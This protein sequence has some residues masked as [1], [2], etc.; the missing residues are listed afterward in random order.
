[1]LYSKVVPLTNLLK[2]LTNSSQNNT[3]MTS[4][5]EQLLQLPALCTQIILEKSKQEKGG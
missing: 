1:M 2:M 5:R 3:F 4:E